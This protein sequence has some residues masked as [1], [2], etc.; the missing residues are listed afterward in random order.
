M[1]RT[2]VRTLGCK[3]TAQVADPASARL[4]IL[5]ILTHYRDNRKL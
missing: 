2:A 3:F 5:T 1:F 4:L